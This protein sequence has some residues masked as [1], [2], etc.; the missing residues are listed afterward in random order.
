MKN[1]TLIQHTLKATLVDGFN[2]EAY[3]IDTSEMS[4]QDQAKKIIEIA[5]SEVI[6]HDYTLKG[7]SINIGVRNWLQ[8]LPSVID[9]PFENYEIIKIGQKIG[10]CNSEAAEDLFIS[11]YWDRMAS[12]L[13]SLATKANKPFLKYYQEKQK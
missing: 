9:L 12:A 7:L 8:G 2:L 5:K 13:V 6:D 10:L 11:S 3:D 1:L 4:I